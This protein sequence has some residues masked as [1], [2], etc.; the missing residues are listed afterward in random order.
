[1]IGEVLGNYRVVRQLGAGGMGSVWLAQHQLLGSHAAIKVLLPEMSEQKRIV[2]RFFDEARAA[3]RIQDPGIV[4]VLDFG[5][6]GASAYIV[7]EHLQGETVTARIVRT[8]MMPVVEALRLLQH[9]ALAMAAAHARG[10]VH[11]DLKPDNIF[12]VDDAAVPGGERTKILDFGIAK[13]IDGADATHS[14]T[15]T[16]VIM[17]TPAYMSPEQCRGAGAVDHRTDIYALGC[18]LFHMLLARPPFLAAAAG[19]LIVSHLRE[20][21]PVPST[22]RD[23][24]PLIV[25]EL[26]A[27]CLAKSADDRYQ[28]MT[29]LVRAIASALGENLSIDTIP[30]L[31]A[32]ET[33]VPESPSPALPVTVADTTIGG[34]TGETFSRARSWRG[35]WIAAALALA[36]LGGIAYVATRDRAPS[37]PAPA[38]VPAARAEPITPDAAPAPADAAGAIEDAGGAAANPPPKPPRRPRPPRRPAPVEPDPYESR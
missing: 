8:G 11:R 28:T 35:G 3:T 5:W 38:A 15:Q 23:D 2:E 36:V 14:R 9:A 33:P 27:R 21:P 22:L 29:D 37:A 31:V 20:D 12:I 26:V 32:R 13:L 34:S 25:D 30:P 19:D 4:T 7:M 17:G 10:I 16:G 6:H 1:M 18:V 24:L